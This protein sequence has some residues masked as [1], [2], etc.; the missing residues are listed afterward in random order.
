MIAIIRDQTCDT[1]QFSPALSYIL[2]KKEHMFSDLCIITSLFKRTSQRSSVY[3]RMQSTFVYRVFE[4]MHFLI[5]IVIDIFLI[6]LNKN[7][8]LVKSIIKIYPNLI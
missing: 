7:A 5:V 3:T 8:E 2:F 4:K 1:K 6:K